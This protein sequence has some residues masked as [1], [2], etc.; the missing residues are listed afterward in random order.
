MD[1]NDSTENLCQTKQVFWVLLLLKV[2]DERK[3]QWE[4]GTYTVRNM[5]MKSFHLNSD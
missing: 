2:F 5:F 3:K 4:G 1:K